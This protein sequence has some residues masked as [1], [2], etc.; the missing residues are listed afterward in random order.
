[1]GFST[2]SLMGA[3]P[4]RTDLPKGPRREPPQSAQIRRD[5]YCS[6]CVRTCSEVVSRYRR[7]TLATTPSQ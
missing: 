3:P 6:S 4:M 7:S 5:M 2:R 1:M